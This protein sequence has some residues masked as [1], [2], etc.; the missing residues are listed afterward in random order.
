MATDL[1]LHLTWCCSSTTVHS[2]TA[3]YGS[4]VETRSVSEEERVSARSFSRAV[5]IS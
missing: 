3:K 4:D 1:P 2:D 5:S